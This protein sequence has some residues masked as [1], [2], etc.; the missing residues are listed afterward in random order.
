VAKPTYE[1]YVG[2]W[3]NRDRTLARKG[4]SV[5]IGAGLALGGGDPGLFRELAE[6]EE[7]AAEMTH[8]WE[9]AQRERE[10]RRTK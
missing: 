9:A 7:Q 4:L 2:L 3:C 1:V 5:A 8:R 10:S 6:N